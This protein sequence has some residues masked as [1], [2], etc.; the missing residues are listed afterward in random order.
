MLFLHS[1]NDKYPEQIRGHIKL[2]SRIFHKNEYI[3]LTELQ[4]EYYS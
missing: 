4:I 1:K 3:V 2:H